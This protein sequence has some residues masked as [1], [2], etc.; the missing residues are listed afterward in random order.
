MFDIEAYLSSKEK[1]LVLVKGGEGSRLLKKAHLLGETVASEG[2]APIKKI[3]QEMRKIFG[4]FG[5]RHSFQ[6][7]PTR[8]V[9]PAFVSRAA[10]FVRN[11]P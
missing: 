11:L 5:G 3:T 8:W 4:D 6:R 7:S 2:K 10:A 9:D 1:E